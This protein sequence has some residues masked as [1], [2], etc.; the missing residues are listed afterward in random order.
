M[1]TA[2][3]VSPSHSPPSPHDTS[4]LIALCRSSVPGWS[5]DE[6]DEH[7]FQLKPLTGG[8]SNVLYTCTLTARSN[9]KEEDHV[10]KRR[11]TETHAATNSTTS[12]SSSSSSSVPS[13]VVVRLYGDSQDSYFSRDY[14]IDVTRE[15]AKRGIGPHIYHEFEKGR[16]EAF[17]EG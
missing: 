16:C 15:L 4:S 5:D 8:M 14:E 6:Y 3:S 11:K 1:Q 7:A 17:L 9:R 12:S 10:D 2:S 13:C